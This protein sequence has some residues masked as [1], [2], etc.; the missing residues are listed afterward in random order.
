MSTLSMLPYFPFNLV[1]I[2]KQ[3]V[4]SDADISQLTAV[5]D[6]RFRPKCHVCGSKA[7]RIHSQEKRSIRDLNIGSTRVWLNRDSAYFM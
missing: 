6:Q 2:I 5:P 1:R 7:Q 4:S 3:S